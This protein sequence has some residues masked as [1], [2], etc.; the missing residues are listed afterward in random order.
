MASAEPCVS[1]SAFGNTTRSSLTRRAPQVL[2]Q[3]VRS[4]FDGACHTDPTEVFAAEFGADGALPG[5]CRGSSPWFWS[6]SSY[7]TRSCSRRELPL[8][9]PRAFAQRIVDR[10][11]S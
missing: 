7:R 1:S 6:G 10:W 2:R 4:V 8:W 3:C 9:L 11:I 5:K